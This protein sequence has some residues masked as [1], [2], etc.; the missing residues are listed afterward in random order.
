[1][2][3]T[4]WKLLGSIA[5]PPP[6]AGGLAIEVGGPLLVGE[7]NSPAEP[8]AAAKD[9]NAPTITMILPRLINHLLGHLE[10]AWHFGMSHR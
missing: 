9:A 10:G 7:A 5:E 6:D 2:S 4:A 1:L 3:I 8:H